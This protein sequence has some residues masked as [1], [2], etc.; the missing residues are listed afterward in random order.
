MATSDR[1]N[2]SYRFASA[3]LFN[4]GLSELLFTQGFVQLGELADKSHETLVLIKLPTG[5]IQCEFRNAAAT[6]PYVDHYFQLPAPV[7][8]IAVSHTV[9]VRLAAFAV[10]RCNGARAQ[11]AD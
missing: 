1:L 6:Q 10:V 8:G 7:T 3:F 5:F 4:P 2:E 11:Q 9:A